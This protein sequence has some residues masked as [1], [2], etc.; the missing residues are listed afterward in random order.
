MLSFI[1]FRF[2]RTREVTM[3]V[4]IEKAMLHILPIY[5]EY[6]C[7]CWASLHIILHDLLFF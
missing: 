2:S 5:N 3:Q 1:A 4:V 7:L 6:M